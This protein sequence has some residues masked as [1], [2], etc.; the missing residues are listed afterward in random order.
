MQVHVA[1]ADPKAMFTLVDN[2]AVASLAEEANERLHR[3]VDTLA[4]KESG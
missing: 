2:A 4:R 3:V 1:V